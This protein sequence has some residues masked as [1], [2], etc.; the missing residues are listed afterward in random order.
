MSVITDANHKEYERA[1][2]MLNGMSGTSLYDAVMLIMY[3]MLYTFIPVL[4]VG[5]LDQPVR[6][7]TAAIARGARVRPPT[8]GPSRMH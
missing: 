5:C 2:N 4:I 8:A 6:A 1:I 3:S 7:S